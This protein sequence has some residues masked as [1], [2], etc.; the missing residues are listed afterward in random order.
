MAEPGENFPLHRTARAVAV[1]GLVAVIVIALLFSIVKAASLGSEANWFNS[2]Y[3]PAVSVYPLL[4]QIW[5]LHNDGDASADYLSARR[6]EIVVELD[7]AAGLSLSSGS[8][9]LVASEIERV[10]GKPVRI[11]AST[12][13]P[14]RAESYMVDEAREIKFR[15]QRY[16]TDADSA[17]LYVLLLTRDTEEDRLVGRTLDEDGM[18]LYL[19]AMDRID[20]ADRTAVEVSTIL[21]E[22]GHQLGLPHNDSPDCLMNAHAEAGDWGAAGNLRTNFCPSETG[23]IARVIEAMDR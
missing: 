18:A 17:V 7:R 5:G 8:A 14:D 16:R 13:L 22:F 23:Q 15:W 6:S 20:Y 12:E 1:V 11:I 21:H 4:R 9:E 10:T 3:R 19:D 2:R